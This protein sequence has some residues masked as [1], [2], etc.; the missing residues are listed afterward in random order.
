MPSG[1]TGGQPAG[2]GAKAAGGMDGTGA[3]RDVLAGAA[4]MDEPGGAAA[5][6]TFGL[7]GPVLRPP[8][9]RQRP[10]AIAGWRQQPPA[11]VRAP[12]RGDFR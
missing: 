9:I 10:L 1:N 11:R 4:A 8:C 12:Q 5:R 2:D 3:E 6:A 7:R